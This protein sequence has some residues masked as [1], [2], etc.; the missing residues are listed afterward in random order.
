METELGV[1]AGTAPYMS[2]EQARGH[3][4]DHRTDVWAFGCVVY[5]LLSA[6]RAFRGQTQLD[7]LA[8]VL[9]REPEWSA[10]PALPGALRSLLLRSLDK[11]LTRRCQS[12]S[13]LRAEL[14]RAGSDAASRFEVRPR[15]EGLVVLP[16]R[17]LSGDP[18]HEFFADGMT[19]A[20]IWDL[21]KLRA[22][23]VISRT[24]AM[25]YKASDKRLPEIA[26]ELN[27][28]AVVEG[29]V[30]RHGERVVIRAQ[31]IQASSDTTIWSESYDRDVRDV[32]ILQSE[33]ARAIAT[34]IEV[35]VSP[36]ENR[37]LTEGA[38]PVDPAA[39]EAYLKGQFHWGSSRR[40][41]SMRRW[42][43]SSGPATRSRRSA[44]SASRPSGSRGSR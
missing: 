21:A 23:R 42:A 18:A 13:D 19:E 33:I 12:A 36:E 25:R 5:E 38:R 4:T 14:V 11:D 22:L 43:T 44:R 26:R 20:L 1:V 29:S 8:A 39:F 10:L 27:V 2:P 41:I 9:Q 24:S 7:T 16:L 28:E 17:N 34:A 6:T 3:P 31:L 35:A 30:A 32:L 40:W 37:Q 15:L